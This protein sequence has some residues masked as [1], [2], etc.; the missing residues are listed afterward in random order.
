MR[1]SLRVKPCWAISRTDSLFFELESPT[2]HV[3]IA[4]MKLFALALLLAVLPLQAS[5][6]WS[7]DY[8]A[9]LKKASAEK[10]PILLE[11]TGSDW[12]PPCKKQ[13]QDVFEQPTFASFAKDNFVAVKLDFPRMKE[14]SAEEKTRNNELAKKYRVQ[15]FP[16]VILL[17][18]EGNELAR[19][20]GYSGG[21]VDGFID[22]FKKNNK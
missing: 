8:E 3:M 6:V 13:A 21:G 14:Q 10:K 19:T 5:D 18:S 9:S 4:L 7:T 2:L 20:V 1:R 16:T 12:C 15:G 11:F 22:W 17:S